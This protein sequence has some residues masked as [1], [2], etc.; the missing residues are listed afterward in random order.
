MM[1]KEAG[2]FQIKQTPFLP[3]TDQE[4]DR[5]TRDRSELFLER[6][7]LRIFVL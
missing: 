3:D 1:A 7:G 4:M 5:V 2:V 6:T